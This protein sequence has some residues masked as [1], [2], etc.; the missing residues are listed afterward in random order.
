[1]LMANKIAFIDPIAAEKLTMDTEF[2]LQWLQV[3]D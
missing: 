1:M 3:F 2:D